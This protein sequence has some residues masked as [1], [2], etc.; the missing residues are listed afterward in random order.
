M[1]LLDKL[2]TAGWRAI[3][4]GDGPLA[5]T[6]RKMNDTLG[7]PLASEDELADRRAFEEGYGAARPA[8]AAGPAPAAKPAEVAPV[9]V[10]YFKDKQWRDA[11][12]LT[13]VLDANGIPYQMFNLEGDEA[14]QAAIRRD[15]KGRG[16]PLCFI[17][18]ECVGGRAELVNL[19][20]GGQ[21]KKRVFGA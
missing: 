6:A 8:A 18:G 5:S 7:R 9:I 11:G 17:A 14:T 21:L 3:A 13:E 19:A 2:R 16:G 15:A 1:G 12:K 10:Y 4:E 20:A